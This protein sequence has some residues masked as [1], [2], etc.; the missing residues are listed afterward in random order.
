M[1]IYQFE[2]KEATDWVLAPDKATAKKWYISFSDCGD[3]DEC[4]VT[5]MKKSEWSEAQIIDPNEYIHPNDPEYDE[6]LYDNG[7]KIIE[8]FADF[9]A[10][11]TTTSIIA[12]TAF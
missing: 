10:R 7:F 6:D 8:S 5:R 4:K 11:E 3:L 12:T 2:W 1:N 9:A